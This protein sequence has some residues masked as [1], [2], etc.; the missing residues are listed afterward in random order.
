MRFS[1]KTDIGR[2]RNTNEDAYLILEHPPFYIFG[3][4]DGMGGHA[5]GEV[6][7]SLVFSVIREF[8]A[9]NG[10][11]LETMDATEENYF[12]FLTNMISEA[13][14]GIWQASRGNR[15]Y[16]GMGTTIT[17]ALLHRDRYYVAH[18]GDSR[19]YSINGE[20]IRQITR[21]H[22]LVEEMVELGQLDK[23][24]AQVHPQR[25]VLTRA[26]GTNPH[27]DVDFYQGDFLPGDTLL[28]C[29]D[30]L[31]SQVREDEILEAFQ[32]PEGGKDAAD[33]LV[34]LANQRG[35]PD[36]ITV[37]VVHNTSEVSR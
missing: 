35:G 29:T 24:F 20:G 37:V 14:Y 26:L 13:N 6:A 21:D 11:G 27:V 4:A 3:V 12:T 28:L 33:A 31:T 34:G 18:V 19:A 22:S 5:A 23:D 1:G 16:H 15:N 7:S 25:H 32:N 2:E 8:L 30:G 9:A 17:L 36:N 10:E